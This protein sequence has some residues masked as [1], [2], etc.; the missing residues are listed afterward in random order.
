MRTINAS[1]ALLLLLLLAPSVGAQFTLTSYS[2]LQDWLPIAML[3]IALSISVVSLYYL[4]AVFL[5]NRRMKARAVGELGQAIGTGIIVLIILAILMFIGGGIF[6]QVPAVSPSSLS[7]L[8][9]QLLPAKFQG[10]QGSEVDFLQTTGTL[11]GNPN[12]TN[13]ICDEVV[14]LSYGHIPTL[15]DGIDYGLFANY[16]ILA[17]VTNQLLNNYNSLYLFEGWIGFVQGFTSVTQVC[18]PTSCALPIG[19]RESNEKY[20]YQPLSGFNA[21]LRITQP[22]EQQGAITFYI[23]FLQLM[24]FMLILYL[25]PWLLAAGIIL[26]ASFFTR[27]VGGLLIALT[28]SLLLILPTVY[29]MEYSAFQNVNPALGLIGASSSTI[30]MFPIYQRN[31]ITGQTTVY[32]SPTPTD[33]YVLSNT[34]S[35]T[36]GCPNNEYAYVVCP[37]GP[38][39]TPIPVIGY[40]YECLTPPLPNSAQMCPGGYAEADFVASENCPRGPAALALSDSYVY[41]GTCGYPGTA[42]AS[43]TCVPIAQA[44]PLCP[45]NADGSPIGVPLN[46]NFFVLPNIGEMLAYETCLPNNLGADELTFAAW[47]LVP[48]YGAVTGILSGF[49]GF[50]GSLPIV[51]TN[52]GPT[53]SCTPADAIM[54]ATVLTNIY[55]ITGVTAYI[56]PLLNVIIALSAAIG[57]SGLLGGDTNILGLGKLL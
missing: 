51:P 25:W 36:Y 10:G 53:L 24:L 32:G 8:C 21:L 52:I 15:T 43:S 40:P 46:I 13:T 48:F 57:I 23:F 49:T 12:P 47:Y 9:T 44:T 38:G 14:P 4:F 3:S 50:V 54:S 1:I 11:N 30:P 20:T 5:N 29:I 17:N 37:S 27:R 35:G 56:L 26:R 33:G 41:E 55:G 31:T 19:P 45:Y 28:L 34:L 18:E 2:E 6:S 22:V 7:T 39:Q 16:L 42:E